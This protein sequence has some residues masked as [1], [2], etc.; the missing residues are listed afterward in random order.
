M[1]LRVRISHG[2]SGP[3]KKERVL[4]LQQKETPHPDSRRADEEVERKKGV[5]L[6]LTILEA[7][8]QP[9]FNLT[10]FLLIQL[11]TFFLQYRA[12]EL[13]GIH[14]NPESE[15]ARLDSFHLDGEHEILLGF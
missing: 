7:N 5:V 15:I 11:G 12:G 8:Q 9:L 1:V 13:I 4:D 3:K 10:L 2:W 14:F 6:R